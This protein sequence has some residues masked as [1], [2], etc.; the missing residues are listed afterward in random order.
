M[1][2]LADNTV[3]ICNSRVRAGETSLRAFARLYLGDR[4]TLPWNRMHREVCDDLQGIGGAPIRLVVGAP[5]G[6]G[7]SSIVSFALILWVLAYRQCRCVVL[8]SSTRSGAGELLGGIDQELRRNLRLRHDF[9]HLNDIARGSGASGSRASPPRVIA[10]R[11]IAKVTTIGPSSRLGEVGF[12]GAPPDLIVLDGFDAG[13][14]EPA[15]PG[16]TSKGVDLL[17]RYLE[18]R[19]LHRF[20]GASVV[21]VGPLL[22]RGDLI[23]RLLSP[24]RRGFWTQRFYAAVERYPDR[25]DLWFTWA[26]LLRRDARGGNAFLEQH[27]DELLAGARVLWPQHESFEKLMRLR[28]ELGWMWFDACR[29][30]LPPGGC[31]RAGINERRTI[32]V[33]AADIAITLIDDAGYLRTPPTDFVSVPE[34][35]KLRQGD[36]PD[37]RPLPIPSPD[38][39][40]HP[41]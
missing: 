5:D 1:R 4:F 25:F 23:D 33:E 41:F 36:V 40:S 32:D 15:G 16:E 35:H 18:R 27:R 38:G 14:N 37:G 6:Y 29:Q 31:L 22:E 11:G 2:T 3:S 9:P 12:E 24:A 26:A 30:G 20:T 28:A 17:E 13:D 10:V 19:I 8:G 34:L 7:K 39:Q 21:V